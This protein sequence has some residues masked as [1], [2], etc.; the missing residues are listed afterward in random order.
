MEADFDKKEAILKV[1]PITDALGFIVAI[2]NTRALAWVLFLSS[3]PLTQDLHNLYE[4]VIDGYQTGELEAASDMQ[5]DW[6]AHALWSLYKDIS[7]FFK[8]QFSEDNLCQGYHIR[9]PLTDYIQE[10]SCFTTM[11]SSGVP[12]C[13]LVRTKQLATNKMAQGGD[14]TPKRPVG[15]GRKIPKKQKIQDGKAQWKDNKKYDATLKSVKQNIVQAHDRINLGMLM[16]ANGTITGKVLSSL[17]NPKHCLWQVF[18][19]GSL[20]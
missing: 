18:I 16:H 11:Y 17:G 1:M 8:K 19:L 15:A 10:I 14:R 2:S 12:P 5:P 13:L 9:N 4:I 20:W 7:K 3:L 6:Y